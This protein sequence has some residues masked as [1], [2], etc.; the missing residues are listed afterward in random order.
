ME[1]RRGLGRKAAECEEPASP[2]F[3]SPY[4]HGFVRVAA[5]QPLCAVADPAFN[6][7]EILKL[8]GKGDAQGVAL[9]VFPE[10]GLSANAIDDLLL[11]QALLDEVQAKLGELIDASR[12]LNPV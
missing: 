12:N 9:M 8:A 2:D 1:N 5:C 6:L 10:L 11:Q 3:H 4:R 7:A